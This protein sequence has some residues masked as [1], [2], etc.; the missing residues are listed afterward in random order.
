MK[1]TPF[2]K[3]ANSD[4]ELLPEYNFNYQK[5]KPNLFDPQSKKRK[6]KVV[7]L[8]DDVA[9]LFTTPELVNKVLYHVR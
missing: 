9:Q 3:S 4:D 1:K 6:M 8:E 2:N 7:V 5:A